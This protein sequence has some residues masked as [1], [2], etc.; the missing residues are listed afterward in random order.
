MI[1]FHQ[2]GKNKQE[3]FNNLTEPKKRLGVASSGDLDRFFLI[4]KGDREFLYDVWGKKYIDCT[5]QGWVSTI[6]HSNHRVIDVVMNVME[7]GLV[8]VRPSYYTIPKL[9][10]AYKLTELAPENLNKV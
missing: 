4:G 1:N 2:I 8:H 3:D 9:E 10:L 6:G 7:N 5:S